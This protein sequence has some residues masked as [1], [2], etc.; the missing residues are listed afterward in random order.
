MNT[1]MWN[2]HFEYILKKI[3]RFEANKTRRYEGYMPKCI[4]NKDMIPSR[5]RY[6][7]MKSSRQRYKDII[8]SRERYKDIISP[9]QR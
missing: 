4:S 2:V 1:W 6:K 7:D 9:R 8:P 3:L 5:D